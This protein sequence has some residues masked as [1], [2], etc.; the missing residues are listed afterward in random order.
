MPSR[1][2]ATTPRTG[3]KNLLP[4]FSH[5]TISLGSTLGT[6]NRSSLPVLARGICIPTILPHGF[7]L[8]IAVEEL[9]TRASIPALQPTMRTRNSLRGT[10]ARQLLPEVLDVASVRKLMPPVRPKQVARASRELAGQRPCVCQGLS[11]FDRWMADILQVVHLD[12]RQV[13]F[14]VRAQPPMATAWMPPM[15]WLPVKLLLS[16]HP[17]KR[18]LRWAHRMFSCAAR[19][20]SLSNCRSFL[21]RS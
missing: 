18:L 17:M 16:S 10:R 19:H 9:L 8:N 15:R 11:N 13:N 12:S 14:E 7:L 1:K 4:L 20:S 6:S 3:S 5:R 2:H 21:L